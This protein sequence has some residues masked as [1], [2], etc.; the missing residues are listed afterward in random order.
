MLSWRPSEDQSGA[1]YIACFIA[2][3]MHSTSSTPHCV[4]LIATPE[5]DEVLVR[6][7]AIQEFYCCSLMK[8]KVKYPFIHES[9]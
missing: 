2:T 7:F 4:P 3:D 5:D 8:D 1:Y 6:H 9:S